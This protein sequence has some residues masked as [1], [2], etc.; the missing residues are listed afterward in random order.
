[1]KLLFAP[2]S[3][4]GSLTAIQIT[5]ILDRVAARHFP[6][7]ETIAIP[8]AD[9]GEGTTDAL[10][11]ADFG[12]KFRIPVTGPLFEKEEASWGMLGDGETAVMEMA[13]A[14][15][16]PYVAEAHRDPRRTTTLGT[17]EM[18]RNAIQR[19]A[20]KL[21]IGIGGS[22]TND[23][24]MGM[25]A[26][27]G[28]KFTDKDGQEVSPVG[29]S[30]INVARADFSGLMPELN[31]IEITVICDV[32]NPLLGESGATWIYGPQKGA[33][34]EIRDELEEGMKNYAQVVSEAIGRD[35]VN[36]FNRVTGYGESTEME[37][38]VAA[39][40]HLR[41]AFKRLI[42]REIEHAEVHNHHAN[43]LGE[44][45]NIVNRGDGYARFG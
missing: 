28:A 18:I 31:D 22:A 17:G 37:K 12:Q 7:A 19:G 20:T 6:G 3:F 13:Q 39:P 36:F 44:L 25:L 24:G 23:G 40:T 10:L 11:R 2:D 45:R 35:A 4:K 43:R 26:A 34:P 15:G 29:G 27:L 41:K 8:V 5:D 9:G 42:R 33:T 32:T 21:L 30:L 1:M 14:S 16:L 38:L